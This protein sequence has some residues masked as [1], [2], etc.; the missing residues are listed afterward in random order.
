MTS[1]T[2]SASIAASNVPAVAL[3]THDDI[4]IAT[5][6]ADKFTQLYYS[7]YD[8]VSRLADLHN[9]YRPGSS[10]TWNGNPLQ[11]AEGVRSLTEN[12]P[13]T[14][15]DMQSFDCHPIPGSFFF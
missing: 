10:L 4:S 2:N 6:A 9:F 13:P 11:G 1:T 14:K 5:R 3:L 7:T 8:S 12:M 15:H